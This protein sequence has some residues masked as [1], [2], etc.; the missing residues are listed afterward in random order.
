MA[1]RTHNRKRN[2]LIVASVF[3]SL[4]GVSG[5]AQADSLKA[6]TPT[7]GKI[8]VSNVGDFY[9]FDALKSDFCDDAESWTLSGAASDTKTFSSTYHCYTP[10]HHNTSWKLAPGSYRV[11]LKL[12]TNGK[13]KSSSVNVVVP[14]TST[15]TPSTSST[16][17]STVA[18][19]STTSV[20]PIPSTIIT[21]PTPPP[22]VGNITVSNVGDLYRFDAL[23]SDFCDDTETWTLSG[24]STYH[25]YTPIHHNT[26]WNLAPGSYRVSLM[27]MT[28]GKATSSSVDVIVPTTATNTTTTSTVPPAPITTTTSTPTVPPT[29]T[30]TTTATTTPGAK[31]KPLLIEHGWDVS[32]AASAA[33]HKAQIDALPFDGITIHPEH[34]PC[35]ATPI[36][37]AQA[38]ADLAPM[39]AFT[40]VTHNFALCRLLDSAAPGTI[41]SA[42]DINNDQVWNTITSNLAVYT[43]AA[44]ETGKFDGILFDTEYYGEGP[45]PWDYDTIAIPWTYTTSRPW[46]LPAAAKAKA[47]A[48]GKQVMDAMVSNW[49][50]ITVFSFRGAEL[51]DS[52]SF[53]PSHIGGNDV[54]WA[55]ELAGPFFVGQVESTLTTAGSQATIVNG[56][57]SYRQ[58]T[59]TDFDNMYAWLKTGQANSNGPIIPSGNV[60]SA[61]FNSKQNIAPGVFD[62]DMNQ[63]GYP[64]FSTAQLTTLLG[65][66]NKAADKYV[67]FYPER[68]DYRGTGWPATPAP[69]SLVSA[70]RAVR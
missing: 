10:I 14:P 24:S 54:A 67:W 63:S 53:L 11:S 62:S 51:S 59:Q 46:S 48:R 13:S 33:A 16:S 12:T 66:A 6:K 57:E 64:A 19:T 23:E 68:F 31:A 26:S 21:V 15:P 40:H 25:C 7:V 61:A 69:A 50:N 44:R 8:T 39:P 65:Y 70:I 27:L 58:R 41:L 4:V 28:N 9:R 45:N 2:L 18:P 5:A 56:G 17:S 49:P 42:Y 1:Y 30:A 43:Q 34:N 47:Q 20:L 3:V 36:T 32:T 55:N 35:S 29:T 37:L 22:V 52:A 60:S 38:R